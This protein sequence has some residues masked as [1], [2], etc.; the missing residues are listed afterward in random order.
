MDPQLPHTKQ[1]PARLMATPQV[2]HMGASRSVGPDVRASNWADNSAADS[3]DG[4][5]AMVSDPCTVSIAASSTPGRVGCSR[6]PTA[7]MPS[8]RRSS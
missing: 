4:G 8:S 5:S 2:M 7:R 6:S 1:L 3:M